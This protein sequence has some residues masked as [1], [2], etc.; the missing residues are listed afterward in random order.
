MAESLFIDTNI[1]MYAV[2]AP[3][4]LKDPSLKILE[5]MS[6]G[7]LVGVT[8]TE[9]FQEVAYRYWSQRKWSVAVQVL[10]DFQPLFHEI[11]AI[12][13]SHLDTYY[14]LLSDYP[15]L[16]PRDA[17]HLAVMQS[18]HI[19]RLCTVDRDFEGIRGLHVVSPQALA[20]EFTPPR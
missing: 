7:C 11:F 2:G 9:V 20:P 14:Q 16:T 19:Q 18:R 17:I 6:T 10:R 12:E 8:D 13:R 1:L 15:R 5:A 4:P 3:H